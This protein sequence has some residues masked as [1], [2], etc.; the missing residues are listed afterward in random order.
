MK[1]NYFRRNKWNIVVL[2]FFVIVCFFSFRYNLITVTKINKGFHLNILTI[3][4]IFAGFLFTSLGIMMSIADKKRISNLEQ[5][6]YMDNYYNA[7]YI[8]L[9]LHVISSL[10][11]ILSILYNINNR[12]IIYA[13]EL[14]LLGG[15][16][17]F[18]KAVVNI[19]SIV[20]KVRSS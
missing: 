17:F 9:F 13:E 16:I 10:I 20:H 6:G 3:N 15:I 18:V 4:S 8:G 14:A 12:F 5:G 2:L 7:I 11:S 19:L 1:K